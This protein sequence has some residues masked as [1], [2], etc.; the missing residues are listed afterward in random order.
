MRPAALV[1]DV[2]NVLYGWDIRLLYQKLIA[3]QQRLDWF[4]SHVVTADWHFQHDLGRPHAETTAELSAQYPDE[5][6]LIAQYVPRWLET[7]AGPMP[8][9]LEIVAEL[10]D[11]GVPLYAITNFSAE[12]WDMFR[13]TAPVFDRFRDVV[14]SGAEK[15]VKPDAAIYRLARDRFGLSADAGLF[16]DDRVEN[17]RA[18]RANGFEAHHFTGA[19]ALRQRLEADGLLQRS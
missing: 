9:V 18:A 5:A 17:V 11:A 6:D 15:V 14:V 8:G 12:F 13:P 16:V 3:D 1:F 10:D 2:G 19:G 7:I 4:L